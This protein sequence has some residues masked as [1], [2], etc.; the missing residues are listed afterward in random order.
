VPTLQEQFGQID[1]YLFD[2]L[3][4]GRITPGM[5]ILDA[6]CG[7]GRNLVYLLREGYEIYAADADPRALESVRSLARTLAPALPASNFRLETVEQMSFEDACADVVISNTVL[8]LAGDDVQFD[9]MLLG[10][11]RVLKP[12]GL[13]FCRL[14]STIGMEGQFERIQGR[15][16][17]S[18]DGAE[19]YLVDEALLASLAQRLGAEL[20]DPIKTTVVQNMRSM[21]T[22]V[23]RK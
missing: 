17:R 5:R 23:L 9:A 20:A 3:L 6:G 1:I 7:G 4:K 22:W 2:Q 15:R 16:Y 8:H 21:T 14:A 18:P 13:F 10:S 12:G 11:W 19:R